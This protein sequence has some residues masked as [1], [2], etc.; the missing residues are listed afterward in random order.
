VLDDQM[1]RWAELPIS[2]IPLGGT[3]NAL[4]KL[5]DGK[6]VRLP[7]IE[8]AEPAANSV[9][10]VRSRAPAAAATTA[11]AKTIVRRRRPFDGGGRSPARGSPLP[12]SWPEQTVLN[13]FGA[14]RSL[15]AG[16]C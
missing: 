5:G 13:S 10:A 15:S 12:V 6:V 2:E 16:A 9:P 7:R 4:C 1:P 8:W 14:V 11:Q 3:E